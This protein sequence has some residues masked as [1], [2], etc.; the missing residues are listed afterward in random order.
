MVDYLVGLLKPGN[1]SYVLGV[2]YAVV[3]DKGPGIRKYTTSTIQ[4]LFQSSDLT[5]TFDNVANSMTSYFR[6]TGT[7]TQI[8]SVK[9]WTIHYKI[10]WPFIALPIFVVFGKQD[11]S[12]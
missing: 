1:D 5:E 3:Y 9:R 7:R 4:S 11:K 2:D 12:V 10:R 8:G 6:N